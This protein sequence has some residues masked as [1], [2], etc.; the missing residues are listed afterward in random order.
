MRQRCARYSPWLLVCLLLSACA[1]LDPG[2]ASSLEWR[3]HQQHLATLEG[4]ELQGRL[5]I[6]GDNE[7][8]TVNIVWRQAAS[9]FDISLSGALGSGAVRISGT[10][11]LVILQKAGEDPIF[12]ESLENVSADFLGYEFPASDL[13]YWIRGLPAP[14][15]PMDLLLNPQQ[16]LEHLEQSDW[17]L[18]YDRYRQANGFYL[19]HQIVLEQAPYRLTFLVNRWRLEQSEAPGLTAAP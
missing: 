12:S 9:S 2:P 13:Y 15:K 10:P 8:N 1:S 5:N 17:Q 6:R 14:S 16:Q 19:P 3:E 4:W 7:S 18:R 11:E